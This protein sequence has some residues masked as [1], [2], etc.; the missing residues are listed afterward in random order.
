MNSETSLLVSSVII[1]VLL[2]VERIMSRMKRSNCCGNI[3]EMSSPSSSNNTE[4][5]LSNI[6]DKSN[7]RQIP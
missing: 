7:N 4:L 1:N 2:I 3:V 5:N 6:N